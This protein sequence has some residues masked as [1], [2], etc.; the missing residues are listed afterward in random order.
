V[1]STP[2]PEALSWVRSRMIA[3]AKRK[4]IA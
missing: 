2:T 3:F 1:G 4:D